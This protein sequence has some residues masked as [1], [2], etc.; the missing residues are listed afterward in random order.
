[1]DFKPPFTIDDYRF[2]EREIA[3]LKKSQDYGVFSNACRR[4]SGGLIEDWSR[5]AD[6]IA[7]RAV[8]CLSAREP[9]SM[10]RL[11]DGE[12]NVLSLADPDLDHRRELNWFNGIFHYQDRQFLDLKTAEAFAVSVEEATCQADAIGVRALPYYNTELDDAEETL[13]GGEVRGSLGM[14]RAQRAFERL[15]HANRLSRATVV[16]AWVHLPLLRHLERLIERAS[17]VIVINGRQELIQPFASRCS[18][19]PGRFIPIPP[20][21]EF[22]HGPVARPNHYPGIYEQVLSLLKQNLAGVLVLVGAGLFGKIYCMEAK[23]SGA[24][25][26]DLGSAFDILA[27]VK[28]RPIHNDASLADVCTIRWL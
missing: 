23:K 3:N 19:K 17:G 26:L 11:G 7:D 1:V 14:L 20:E 5:G 24:V 9:F 6:F 13:K 10:V 18:S 15:L 2:A 22:F 21:A 12:G 4:L 28:T 27:G 16:S 25:A 8:A